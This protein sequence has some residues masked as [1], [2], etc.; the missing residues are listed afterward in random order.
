MICIRLALEQK[1]EN[2]RFIV[3]ISRLLRLINPVK[4]IMISIIIQS[5]L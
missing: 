3:V 1:E 2:I 4:S 5:M